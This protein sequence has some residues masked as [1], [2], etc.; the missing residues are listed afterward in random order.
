MANV[1]LITQSGKILAELIENQTAI[2]H[3]DDKKAKGD[4]VVSFGTDGYIL[5]RSSTVEVKAGRT[6][7]IKCNGLVLTEDIIIRTTNIGPVKYLET[8][9]IILFDDT[10][11][12]PDIPEEPDIPD[13]P[14]VPDIPEEPDVPETPEEPEPLPGL[15]APVIVLID[16]SDG[17]E[18]PDEPVGPESPEEQTA[19][20]KLGKA[21]LGYLILGKRDDD[22]E[23]SEPPE[24]PEEP[25]LP[26]LSTPTIYLY[27]EEIDQ[28]E[29]EKPDIP[30]P[31][32][33]APVI[34]IVEIEEPKYLQSPK[35]ELVEIDIPSLLTTAILGKD[36][37]GQMVLGTGTSEP[38]SELP[39][40]STP[41]I[42][43]EEYEEKPQLATPFV[44]LVEI[45]KPDEPELPA[46][47]E[48][49]EVALTTPIIVL[50]DIKEEEEE[51]QELSAPFIQLIEVEEIDYPT[52]AI[53][54]ESRLGSLILGSGVNKLTQLETPIVTLKD[55]EIA[56]LKQ[57]D[58]YI[59]DTENA[60]TAL[61]TPSII[62]IEKD[63]EAKATL[64]APVIIITETEQQ[65]LQLE[66]P[67]IHI[68]SEVSYEIEPNEY[69][70]TII[71]GNYTEEPNENGITIIIT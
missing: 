60:P 50:N 25:E 16:I 4:I 10:P 8:P 13:I 65:L 63:E 29:E 51:K 14:D 36:A 71:L 35:I 58:I 30:A 64:D 38:D 53:L 55:V 28:P 68:A 9:V 44:Q 62:I 42:F 27:E 1:T 11:E 48:L 54:G 45:E 15:A 56:Q 3:T 43:I 34:N 5:Y 17:T 59:I 49:P 70:S 39:I 26:K 7:T 52:D 32:L 37:L 21:L 46:D 33:E 40:L 47:P 12:L 61:S 41:V 57:P 66:A 23:P 2:I 20:A 22:E 18:E 69:G 6:A 67:V 24:E 31:E 19:T